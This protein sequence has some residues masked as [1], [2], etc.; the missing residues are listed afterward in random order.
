[1][2]ADC[3]GS[4]YSLHA[5]GSILAQTDEQIEHYL[6]FSVCPYDGVTARLLS[7]WKCRYQNNHFNYHFI[8]DSGC[9]PGCIQIKGLSGYARR[10]SLPRHSINQI[11]DTNRG[12]YSYLFGSFHFVYCDCHLGVEI[13]LEL[14]AYFLLPRGSIL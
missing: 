9:G 6:G 4:G 8:A 7:H 13:I 2:R 3:F 14:S 5:A 10:L 11:K 1:M 12:V